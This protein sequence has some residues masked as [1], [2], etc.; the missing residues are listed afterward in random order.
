MAVR[1]RAS[2]AVGTG[3]A[4]PEPD[5]SRFQLAARSAAVGIMATL[6]KPGSPI[7]S[8]KDGVSGVCVAAS[9]ILVIIPTARTSASRAIQS[10]GSRTEVEILL[11]FQGGGVLASPFALSNIGESGVRGTVG[12]SVDSKAGYPR[13][14]ALNE[15]HL[16]GVKS[17]A[18]RF[19]DGRAT[20]P[21][22]LRQVPQRDSVRC[23]VASNDFRMHIIASIR[24]ASK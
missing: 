10:H 21:P 8:P 2:A 7:N 14:S 23:A 16:R 18:G 12:P 20:E 4:I 19:P 15:I 5:V 17:H 6:L 9:R 24:Q 1:P 13:N 11:G 22:K 3:G